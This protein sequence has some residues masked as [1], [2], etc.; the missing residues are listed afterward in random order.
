MKFVPWSED[1]SQE[2]LESAMLLKFF[3]CIL[4]HYGLFY[5]LFF[6]EWCAVPCATPTWTQRKR[7]ITVT[8]AS[9]A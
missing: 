9:W 1:I 3:T 7:S 6:A 4:T 5:H 2:N 8:L